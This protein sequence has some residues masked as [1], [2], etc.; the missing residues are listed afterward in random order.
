MLAVLLVFLFDALHCTTVHHFLTGLLSF[1]LQWLQAETVRRLRHMVIG[2]PGAASTLVTFF[3]LLGAA[4]E[5]GP[6]GNPRPGT[7]SFVAAGHHQP[8][9]LKIPACPDR[10]FQLDLELLTNRDEHQVFK[11]AYDLC[12]KELTDTQSSNSRPPVRCPRW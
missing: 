10:D 2:G 8:R 1:K 9:Q 3:I 7:V 5:L 6:G 4:S 11:L 12:F